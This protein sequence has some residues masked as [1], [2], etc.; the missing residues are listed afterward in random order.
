[1]NENNVNDKDSREIDDILKKLRESVDGGAKS[2]RRGHSSDGFEQ[3]LAELL[4]KHLNE[5]NDLGEIGDDKAEY[6]A[7]DLEIMKEGGVSPELLDRAT[8]PD[9]KR[10]TEEAG[11]AESATQEPKPGPQDVSDSEEP[12]FDD[13]EA[14]GDLLEPEPPEQDFEEQEIQ[15][16]DTPGKPEEDVSEETAAETG[17][18]GDVDVTLADEREVSAFSDGD[19]AVDNEAFFAGEYEPYLEQPGQAGGDRDTDLEVVTEDEIPAAGDSG[20]TGADVIP[21]AGDSENIAASEADRDTET[22]EGSGADFEFIRPTPDRAQL[23]HEFDS[24]TDTPGETEAADSREDTAKERETTSQVRKEVESISENDINVMLALGYEKELGSRIGHDRVNDI[25]QSLESR[26]EN[27][28]KDQAGDLPYGIEYTSHSQDA[29]IKLAYR[30]QMMTEGFRLAGVTFMAL[31]LGLLENLAYI[32]GG[33]PGLPGPSSPVLYSLTATALLAC[34]AAMSY[35]ILAEGLVGIYKFDPGPHSASAMAVV[36]TVV[37]NLAIMIIRPQVAQLYNFPAALCLVF[38]ALSELLDALREKKT[39]EVIS[40]GETRYGLQRAVSDDD[41]IPVY[42]VRRSKFTSGYLRRSY[43]KKKGIYL[44]NYILIPAVAVGIVMAIITAAMNSAAAPAVAGFMATVFICLPVPALLLSLP[45]A[46]AAARLK[47][48]GCA[49]VGQS[50]V[51]EYSGD[52]LIVF[53]DSAM[54]PANCIRTKGIKLYDGFEIYD[55][56]VKVGSLFCAVGGPLGEMFESGGEK[57]HSIHDVKLIRIERGGVEA[58]IGGNLH[59]LCGSYDFLEKYG[60]YPKRNPRDEQLLAAGEVSIIYVAI[61]RRAAARLYIDYRVDPKF[62]EVARRLTMSNCRV[63]IRT[64][65][66]GIDED[67]LAR[68]RGEG[69]YRVEIIRRPM[70]RCGAVE[71]VDSGI[72]ALGSPYDIKEPLSAAAKL[73]QMRRRILILSLGAFM[74]NILI[75][76]LL[77]VTGLLAHAVSGLVALYMLLWSL[78]VLFMALRATGGR[79]QGAK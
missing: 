62:E 74:L 68:K 65:D 43:E 56:L 51:E 31:L 76:A 72:V 52:K 15:P 61:D 69:A 40:S 4:Q 21:A 27:A 38:S 70:D 29:K 22:D 42:F 14:A 49:L 18:P 34:A 9:F 78:P 57:F 35:G 55:V 23:W 63:A 28:A 20:D 12:A 53:E 3:K 11:R 66:P 26:R 48:Q 33:I 58:Q 16:A 32:G 64:C 1:M 30:R 17:K 45:P 6:N 54:F 8:K 75:S 77:A 59:M 44:L 41:K 37:S 60:V 24:R 46:F 79:Q 67:M 36:L 13:A 10:Q 71:T 39:F 2:N 5:K 73:S 47:K 25:K 50:G 19:T 7:G